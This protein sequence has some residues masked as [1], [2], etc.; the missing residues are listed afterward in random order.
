MKYKFLNFIIM[1]PTRRSSSLE[2]AQRR[3]ERIRAIVPA[4]NFGTGFSIA[5][6]ETEVANLGLAL[7]EY[8]TV[9]AEADQ[10]LTQ[11]KERERSIR[12]YRERLLTAIAFV[13][14]KDSDEYV[15]AGGIRKSERKRPRTRYVSS[16]P[17]EEN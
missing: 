17:M 6:Y 9:V 15:A 7:G 3:L 16:A 1:R 12:D 2:D 4:P 14:G 10:K 5:D 13:Y 8:N 11:L